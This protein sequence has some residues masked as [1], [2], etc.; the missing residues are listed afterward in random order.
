MSLE[1]IIKEI[2]SLRPVA[3]EDV[4]GGPLNTLA[5]RRGRKNQALIRLKDLREEYIKN[6]I[7]SSMFIIVTGAKRNEFTALATGEA[8]G[9]FSAD[10]EEFY[11]DL[12]NRAPPT[13]YQQNASASNLFDILGRHLEDKMGELGLSEYNQLIFREKYISNVKSAN[14]FAGVLKVAI[15]E[16][17]GSEIVGIQ[18][19]NSIAN[20]AITRG[21]GAKT[22]PIVLN[23]GDDKLALQLSADLERLTNRVFVVNVGKAAKE[24]KAVELAINLKDATEDSVKAA[25]DQIKNSIKK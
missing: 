17:I 12:A 1:S 20:D 10:P 25:L 3:N 24:L 11:K 8:F 9:L 16:Q 7:R 6:L 21:H 4:E 18:A 2:Q 5:G 22:T 23:T 14:D 13:L 19:V 15:N